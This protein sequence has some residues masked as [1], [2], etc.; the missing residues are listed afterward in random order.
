MTLLLEPRW[1]SYLVTTTAPILT[2]QQCD[3]VIQIGQAQPQEEGKVYVGVEKRG[4]RL[5]EGANTK[6]RNAKISWIPFKAARPMYSIIERWML[7]TNLNHFGF[8]G[9]TLNEE[10]QYTEYPKGDFMIGI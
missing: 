8:D 1:K 4:K 6:K 5:K 3:E 7:N 9:M 10:A 2:P